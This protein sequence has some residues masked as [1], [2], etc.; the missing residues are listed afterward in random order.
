MEDVIALLHQ[1]TAVRMCCYQQ[2]LVHLL[3]RV[4]RA[5]NFDVNFECQRIGSSSMAVP[6]MYYLQPEL[7]GRVHV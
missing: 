4:T 3:L 5:L 1:I 6:M 7:S 2:D